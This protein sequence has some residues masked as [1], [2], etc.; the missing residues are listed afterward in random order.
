MKRSATDAQWER[1]GEQNPYF[2]VLGWE[3]SDIGAEGAKSQFF[4]TGRTHIETVLA[5]AQRHLGGPV[6]RRRA[7][8]FGCGVGRLLPPLSAAFDEVIGIDI[9]PRMIDL[10]RANTAACANL[11]FL[12]NVDDM[13]GDVDLVHSYIV[14]QHIRPTQG[15]AILHSLMQRVAP[16]GVFILHVT[17]GDSRPLRAA[18]N[19][20]RYRFPPLH[21]AYNLVRRRPLSEPITEMNSY[22]PHAILA[23][24]ATLGFDGAFL[25]PLDQNGHRGLI[26]YGLRAQT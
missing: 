24:A 6:H 19:A 9:S 20:L 2:G 4:Q 5:T 14:L 12:Q 15:M 21:W 16:G 26:F 23:M 17:V 3:S 13:V 7:V 25:Q 10:A 22:N 1:W 8:D 18:L 11:T